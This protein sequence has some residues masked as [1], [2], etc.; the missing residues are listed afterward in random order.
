[1]RFINVHRTCKLALAVTFAMVTLTSHAAAQ[2]GRPG[3]EGLAGLEELDLSDEQLGRIQDIR[4][5]V[6]ASAE[7][8][9]EQRRDMR[10]QLRDAIRSEVVNEGAIRALVATAADVEANLVILRAYANADILAILTPDQRAR[11]EE[12]RAEREDEIASRLEERRQR[13]GS[14]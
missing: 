7:P 13:R 1:M 8:L 10:E 2:P 5:Q 6:R 14:R 3:G 9:M 11:L 4:S 12:I